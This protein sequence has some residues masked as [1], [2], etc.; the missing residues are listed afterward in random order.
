VKQNLLRAGF[1]LIL[2]SAI[3]PATAGAH[4]GDGTNT[5][6]AAQKGR[7]AMPTGWSAG[8]VHRWTGYI[9]P[10]G[11]RRVRELQRRLNRLGYESGRVDGLFG[12]IT[13]RATKRFQARNGLR[14][15]GIVGPRTLRKLRQRDARRRAERR[16][17]ANQRTPQGDRRSLERPTS[18]APSVVPER[19]APQVHVRVPDTS[20]PELPALPVIVAFVLL[21]VA[22]FVT[23]YVKTEA[24][25]RQMRGDPPRRPLGLGAAPRHEGGGG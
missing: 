24:R 23:G 19:V 9:R 13:E 20:G 3:L 6:T 11:S 5:N 4:S 17:P 12:P 25:I 1:A 21:G 16:T 8:Q 18:G 2:L 14:V 7:T 10:G 22:T 15:D